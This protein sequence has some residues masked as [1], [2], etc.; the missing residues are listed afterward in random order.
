MDEFLI[1]AMAEVDAMY[2]GSASLCELEFSRRDRELSRRDTRARVLRM[3][4]A[5]VIC[6]TANVFLAW[7]FK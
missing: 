3:A 5:V 2:P 1:E 6:F 7:W 4:A